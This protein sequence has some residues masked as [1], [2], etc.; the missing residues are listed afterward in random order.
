MTS[1]VNPSVYS[2]QVRN[3][4]NPMFRYLGTKNTRLNA[5]S[6]VKVKLNRQAIRD[7][8][9]KGSETEALINR[10]GQ[11]AY[12]RIS[13][14]EGYV[15]EDRKYPER[16]GVAIYAQDYPAISDNLQNNTLLKAVK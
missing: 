13:N 3:T 11:E 15:M 6:K 16:I 4:L 10:Y 12:G 8:L 2:V 1:L 7:Q 5:M 9:L 14:I